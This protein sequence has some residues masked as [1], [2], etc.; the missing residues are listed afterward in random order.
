[1]NKQLEKYID[2]IVEDLFSKTE[3]NE[4]L[5]DGI[6]F[7]P[8]YAPQGM[9]ASFTT[10]GNNYSAFKPY[11]VK[12]YGVREDESWIIFM[13]YSDKVLDRMDMKI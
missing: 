4:N 6:Y 12:N 1:M 10:Y 9:P 8:P 11:V 5:S 7:Y 13:R 3:F 2:Y